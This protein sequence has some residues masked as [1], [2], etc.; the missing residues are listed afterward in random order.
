MLVAGLFGL[1]S[2]M[3]FLIFRN[4]SKIF[5]TTTGRDRASAQLV[6]G[7]QTIRRDLELARA[8]P[9][10][11]S[12]GTVPGSLGGGADSDSLIF[13][14]PKDPVSGQVQTHLDGQPFW[15]RNILYYGVVPNDYARLIGQAVAGGNVGGYEMNCPVKQLVRVEIDQNVGNDPSND[16]TEDQLI[17]NPSAYLTRPTGVFSSSARRTVATGLLSFSCRQLGPEIRIDLRAVSIEEARRDKGFSAGVSYASGRYT[18]QQT[19]S[20]FSH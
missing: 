7:C 14:S 15:M 17:S 4:S 6:K 3:S 13:L 18:L 2:V 8:T 12:I 9:Q 10:T 5:A 1:L 19:F 16:S 11:L 20:V